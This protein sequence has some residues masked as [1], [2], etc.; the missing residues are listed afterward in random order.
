M[1][2]LKENYEKFELQRFFNEFKSY[3][4][5][6]IRIGLSVKSDDE[7]KIG[8]SKI[9]GSPDLPS[10]M[11]WFKNKLTGNDLSFIAQINFA[12][13]K[14]F[15]AQN[16]LP[17]SG[18]LYLFYDC[19]DMPWGFDPKD[20]SGT[21]IFYFEGEI[22]D[23][24]RRAVEN[25]ELL[26][27]FSPT[28]L[29]FTSHI[30]LSGMWSSLAESFNA[31]DE[32]A[33]AFWEML[34]EQDGQMNKILGH[35]D[36][37]QGGMELECELVSNGIYCGDSLGYKHP[38]KAELEKNISDWTLLLQ[39]DSNEENEMMWGDCGRLYVWIKDDD[40]RNKRFDKARLILQCS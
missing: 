40:L 17:N 29:N 30:E 23:L 2:K 26:T 19:Y 11:P 34:D 15:D 14:P 16:K 10:D 27:P 13:V 18:I 8:A 22:G 6:A 9:G 4:K 24:K 1:Q 33:D 38:L 20:V 28:V 36:N 3:A 12:E 31:S 37:I 39:I 7:I 32:E 21:K 25:A 35:S 5:N